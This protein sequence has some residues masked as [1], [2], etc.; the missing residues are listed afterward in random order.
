LKENQIIFVL[1]LIAFGIQ[2]I[3]PLYTYFWPIGWD[4]Y[5]HIKYSLTIFATGRIPSMNPYFPEF[6][7]GYTLGAHAL[8]ATISLVGGLEDKQIIHLFSLLPTIFAMPITLAFYVLA[9]K[10]VKP[11]YAILATFL[12]FISSLGH[13]TLIATN[14]VPL[15]NSLLNPYASALTS[16]L[17]F[18]LFIASLIRNQEHYSKRNMVITSILFATI[19]LSYHIMAVVALGLLITYS[20]IIILIKGGNKRLIK[21]IIAM[22]SLGL[23]LASPYILHIVHAGPPKETGAIRTYAILSIEDYVK[24]LHPPLFIMMML[25]LLLLMCSKEARRTLLQTVHVQRLIILLSWFVLLIVLA[26]S[27]RFGIVLVNDRFAWYLIS[28]A[29]IMAALGLSILEGLM[30]RYYNMLMQRDEPKKFLLTLYCAL[31]LGAIFCALFTPGIKQP[32]G[33]LDFLRREIHGIEWLREHASGSTVI[34]DPATSFLIASLTNVSIVT[35]PKVMAD[36]YVEGLDQRINDLKVAFG[37]ALNESLQILSKYHVKYVYIGKETESWFRSNNLNPYQLLNTPYFKPVF[38][39]TNYVK[40]TSDTYDFNGDGVPETFQAL[41]WKGTN[42]NSKLYI[43]YNP[44]LSTTLTLRCLFH[45]KGTYGPIKIT[46]NNVPVALITANDQ[47]RGLWLSYRITIPREIIDK[48]N[49]I[50]VEN[51]DPC[52]AFYLDYIGF[53]STPSN[54]SEYGMV[55]TIYEVQ[56]LSALKVGSEAFDLDNDGRLDIF[57]CLTWNGGCRQYY[58]Y[59]VFGNETTLT[60][61]DLFHEKGT[62]GPIEIYINGKKCGQLMLEQPSE[63]M[64][65]L[66]HKITL[67]KGVIKS[68]WNEVKFINLDKA[69][70]WYLSYVQIS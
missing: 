67:P 49:K 5:Y 17:L 8:V 50:L 18:P 46:V 19:V 70:N 32:D 38:P 54:I 64:K 33:S 4:T 24:I 16:F 23:L 12:Y 26:E 36:Y 42:K 1:L 15:F 65:W 66:V 14:G 48:I 30:K 3:I 43:L 56:Y 69:N 63:R 7:L 41:L 39:L 11:A 47:E 53:D 60:I 28:P 13:E 61:V 20:S 45:K 59:S 51:L 22:T 55:T 10:Y 68:G 31:L 40:E 57:D 37:G 9:L 2:I 44:N 6:P 25:T 27:H 21:S 52:N 35:F 34:T 58:L 29:S 62:I